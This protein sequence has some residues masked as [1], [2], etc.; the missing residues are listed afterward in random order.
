[1]KLGIMQPYL[2]PYVGYFNLIKAVDLFVLYDDVNFIKQGWIN[3]NNL[4]ANGQPQMF[5]VPLR[6][7][8]SFAH[9]RDVEIN[10]VRYPWFKDK[11]NKTLEQHYHKA[12]F[13]FTIMPILGKVF[14]QDYR[15]ISEISYESISEVCKYLGIETKLVESFD[16]YGNED[17]KREKRVIDICEKE[18]ADQYINMIGGKELYSK[19]E[20][21][22]KDIELKF[23]KPRNIQYKQFNSPFVPWLSIIDVLMFNSPEE[24]NRILKE[25]DLS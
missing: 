12:P 6:N 8:S 25:Y 21:K 4:L 9:I 3:R 7:A 5:T 24:T 10:D 13:F 19:K 14:E 15:Y 20:F 22:E 16:R 18:N 11:I 2:F 17:L 1:M 23:L